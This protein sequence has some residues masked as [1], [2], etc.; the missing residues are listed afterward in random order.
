MKRSSKIVIWAIVA[1]VIVGLG[2]FIV[3]QASGDSR[4]KTTKTTQV[5][6]SASK[7]TAPKR[8]H[9]SVKSSK[10]SSSEQPSSSSA[11][12]AVSSVVKQAP[13]ELDKLR[14]N[15]G[16]TYSKITASAEGADTI[17][18][19]LT[20]AKSLAANTDKGVLKTVLVK[21][22]LPAIQQAKKAQPKVT[23]KVVLKNP[24]GSEVLSGPITQQEINEEVQ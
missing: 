24:D 5:K 18:Y 1:I 15:T 9:H 8:K 2:F 20:L 10:Q 22:L 7:K 3:H 23:L 21:A 6:K 16:D 14:A 11:A 19:T 12:A 4:A 17:V 13:E